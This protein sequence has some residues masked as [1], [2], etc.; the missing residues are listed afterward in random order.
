MKACVDYRC[1]H[2]E[3]NGHV[4]QLVEQL[5]EEQRVIRSTR[6]VSTIFARKASRLDAAFIAVANAIKANRTEV[7][8]AHVLRTTNQ[9]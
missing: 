4:A 7:H 3:I 8:V 9:L 6:I 5:P 1:V 2:R